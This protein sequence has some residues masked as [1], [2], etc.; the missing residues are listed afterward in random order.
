MNAVKAKLMYSLYTQTQ[1]VPHREHIN[2][3]KYC[4]CDN[5]K[6]ICRQ[7]VWETFQNLLGTFAKLRRAA[8]RFV[9]SVCPSIPSVRMQ[10]LGSHWTDIHEICY[11]SIFGK[12]VNKIQ[13]SLNS[14]KNNRYFTSRPIY[15]FYHISLN[16]SYNEKCFRQKL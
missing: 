9:M 1:F 15:I 10:H 2:G 7:S 6:V 3:R 12:S 13:V 14:D 4:F 16:S 11:L 8:I 5:R